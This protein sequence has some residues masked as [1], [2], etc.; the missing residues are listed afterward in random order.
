MWGLSNGVL[1]LGIAGDFWIGIIGSVLHSEII[2]AIGIIGL[3]PL[4]QGFLGLRRKSAGFSF[5]EMKSG[6]E[7]QRRSLR[8]IRRG[9]RWAMLIETGL[10]AIA[11]GSVEYFHRPDLLWPALGIA[12]SLHFLPLGRLFG[13]RTYYVTGIAGATVC[14]IAVA[15]LNTPSNLLFAA[16]CMCVN[17][18]GTAVWL[19]VRSDQI[20]ARAIRETNALIA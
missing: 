14:L 16:I 3:V 8:R 15:A 19:L 12:V 9:F 6:T 11:V 18:W 13:V 10:C 17:M 4:L 20:A 2:G 5:R 1:V 7:E